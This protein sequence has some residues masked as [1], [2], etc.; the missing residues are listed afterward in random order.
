MR[1]QREIITDSPYLARIWVKHN[2]DPSRIIDTIEG[3]LNFRDKVIAKMPINFDT[4]DG[5]VRT[6]NDFQVLTS[7]ILL[8]RR[9]LLPSVIRM[10]GAINYN[11]LIRSGNRKKEFTA[12]LSIMT[13]H[14]QLNCL[15]SIYLEMSLHFAKEDFLLTEPDLFEKFAWLRTFIDGIKNRTNDFMKSN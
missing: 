2:V 11:N 15:F 4:L 12:H 6:E 14:K 5:I 1:S 13:K 10:T 8:A 9:F 7:Q 3:L